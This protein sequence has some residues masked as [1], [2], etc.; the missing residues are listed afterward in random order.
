M[1]EQQREIVW[2]EVENLLFD[3]HNPRLPPTISSEGEDEVMKW[4]LR[5][6]SIIE[7]MGA[8]GEKGYFA[9]EP[10]L[11]VESEREKN[12]FEV[13]EGNRRLCAVKLL[14]NPTIAPIRKNAVKEVAEEAKERPSEIPVVIYNARQDILD[15]L[16]YR[17]ITGI[18]EWGALAKAKYLWQLRE[19]YQDL[20]LSTQFKSLAK[21]IGSKS[22]YVARL[23]TGYNL[24][25]KVS[26]KDFF[27]LGL[28]EDS[29]SFSILTTALSYNNITH[30]IGLKDIY[31]AEPEGLKIDRLK[32]V[33][34]WM[35]KT[36]SQGNT[37]LGES[38]NLSKL[39]EIINSEVALHQFQQGATIDEAHKY[40][41]EPGRIFRNALQESKRQI[42]TARDY[43]HRVDDLTDS[44]A[45]TAYE[46]SKIAR[47][48]SSMINDALDDP[49]RERSDN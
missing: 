14:L 40:T 35:F 42:T 30:Y 45:A 22:N 24:L 18:K 33:I 26:E 1:S 2:M 6:A 48:T 8:I 49:D 3:P 9:G 19:S 28:D 12:K 7:L 47:G 46:V 10:V 5:D 27:D 4:L 39:S 29:I 15:Y 11:V 25:L 13:V 32:D 38:R 31:D 21:A 34:S 36:S 16:G 37:R 23:L 43:V 44:D 41:E 17:H 20:P